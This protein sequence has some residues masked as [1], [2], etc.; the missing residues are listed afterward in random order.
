MLS[1]AKISQT[2]RETSYAPASASS[3]FQG[4]CDAHSEPMTP[5]TTIRMLPTKTAKKSSTRVRPRRSRYSPWTWN[6]IG[7]STATNGS[8]LTYCSKGGWPLVTGISP[9]I[10]VSKRSR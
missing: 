10:Q 4:Y 7:T 8:R 9:A 3:L 2:A 6:A 1:S 5:S